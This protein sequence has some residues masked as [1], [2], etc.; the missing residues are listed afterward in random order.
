MSTPSVVAGKSYRFLPAFAGAFAA[1]LI[2]TN[3]LNTKI[4]SVLGFDFPGGIL[5]FPLSFLLADALTET[6]GYSVTRRVIWIGFACLGGMA[7]ILELVVLL[8]PA[9]FWGQQEAFAGLF[10]QI[11]RIVTASMIAY[12]AGEFCNSYVLAKSKVRTDGRGMPLRFVTSTMA[13]QAA[14]T[15]AFMTIAFLGVFPASAMLKLFVASWVFKV[16]WEIVA[17]PLSVPFV[18]Y[19][20]RAENEDWFDRGTDFNPF[21]L[22]E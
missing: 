2:L 13:G 4:F 3:V 22:R 16:A 15:V 7:A 19:V 6:Y 18:R 21:R 9:S 1:V 14:D 12:F 5:T 11:P 20:K 17:L 10:N 8:P